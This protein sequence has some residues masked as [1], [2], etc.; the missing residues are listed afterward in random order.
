M[1][2]LF[3]TI[4]LLSC[5]RCIYFGSAKDAVPYFLRSPSK[6]KFTGYR[7]PADF[8]V[9]ISNCSLLDINV[10]LLLISFFGIIIL[11]YDYFI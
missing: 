7:N 5:G 4:Y 1:Y 11:L 9:D 6:F 2:E 10:Y 3:D 8:L